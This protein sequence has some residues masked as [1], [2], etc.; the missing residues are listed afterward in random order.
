MRI[1][2]S[3]IGRGAGLPRG[4]VLEE[5]LCVLLSLPG[6]LGWSPSLAGVRGQEEKAQEPKPCPGE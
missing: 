5:A 3:G 1:P 6:F 2:A 4:Q